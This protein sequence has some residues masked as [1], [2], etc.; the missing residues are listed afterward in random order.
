MVQLGVFEIAYDDG[1][2][3]RVTEYGMKILR[4]EAHITLSRYTEAVARE[5][6][7]P[8][9]ETAGAAAPTD[10]AKAL[11]E[12]LKSVR[13]AIARRENKPPYVIFSDASLLDMAMRRPSTEFDFLGVTGVG[14][15]KARRYGP[16][17]LAAI[18]AFT[19]R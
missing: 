14:E 10:A 3:L 2:H 13:L 11:F 4:G 1:N 18:A 12:H 7:A 15:Y 19:P 16:E 6:K 9:R 17:F 5:R 8:T